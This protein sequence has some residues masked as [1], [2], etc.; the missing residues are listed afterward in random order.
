MQKM[1]SE[2]AIPSELYDA[3]MPSDFL[4]Y[5][6]ENKALRNFQDEGQI[7]PLGIQGQGLFRL[8][9]EFAHHN[10]EAFAELLA[11]L[12]VIDWFE[13]L[14]LPTN[15]FASESLLKIEDR[16]LEEGFQWFDQRSANEGFLF[17]LFYFS[18]FISSNTP[19]FFAIDN[20]E[21]SFNPK[22]CIEL[23]KR[24]VALGKSKDKQVIATTHNPAVLDGLNLM[25]EEQRLFV[26]RRNIDGH[27]IAHRVMPNS[28][29]PEVRLSEA[30][31]RGYLGG[32]PNNF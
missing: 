9:K 5:S 13:N 12:Q 21:A 20:I 26:L 2:L 8:V 14:T 15:G 17:L 16:F 31:T 24:L 27:T 4:I 10:E 6:P 23:V 28:Y 19:K 18:L 32:L 1:V 29:N 22:L 30:W 3:E 25:D 7:L 11:E